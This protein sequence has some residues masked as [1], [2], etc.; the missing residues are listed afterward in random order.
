MLHQLKQLLQ[1]DICSG[2]FI[3]LGSYQTLPTINHQPSISSHVNPSIHP[4]NLP[5]KNPPEFPKLTIDHL[6]GMFHSHWQRHPSHQGNLR[7]F[8]IFS[9]IFA[10]QQL[11][12]RGRKRPTETTCCCTLLLGEVCLG[13]SFRYPDICCCVQVFCWSFKNYH[14]LSHFVDVFVAWIMNDLPD[15]LR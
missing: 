9:H 5:L 2:L 1:W 8:G 15:V 6:L 3:Q 14:E 4:W 7:T 11:R 12:L 13:R 10:Q